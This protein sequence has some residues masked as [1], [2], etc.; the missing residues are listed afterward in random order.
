MSDLITTTFKFPRDKYE[1]LKSYCKTSGFTMNS[2]FLQSL[3]S[4]LVAFE[5]DY[6]RVNKGKIVFIDEFADRGVLHE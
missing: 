3:D 2:L 6:I 5:N 4:W 1:L